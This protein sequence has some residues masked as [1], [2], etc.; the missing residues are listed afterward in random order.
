MKDK[1]NKINATHVAMMENIGDVI[2]IMEINGIT[3]Y[4]SPNIEKWFGWKPK[5]VIG[6]NGWKFVHPDDLRWVQ[7]EFKKLL[8][9]KT[10]T[11]IE[12]RFNHKNNGYKWIELTAINKESFDKWNINELP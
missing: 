6:K 3:K 11:V 9:K 1:I 5:D 2:A 12:F 10:N 4:Q 7:K 8:L